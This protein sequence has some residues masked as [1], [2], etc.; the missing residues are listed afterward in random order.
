MS[1]IVVVGTQWG[2][3]GKGKI[4]DFLAQSADDVVRYQG[5]N[6]AGHSIVFNGNKYALHLIPSGIF[7]EKTKNIMANGMVINPKALHEEIE[8]LK[9]K[10]VNKFNLFISNRA[11]VIMPYHIALDG[12]IEELKADNNVGTT[13]KGIGPAYT[14]KAQRIGI[15]M[16]DFVNPELFHKRLEENLL[17][18]NKLLVALNKPTFDVEE[19]YNEYIKYSEEFKNYVCDTSI[20]LENEYNEQSKILF[21]GAQGVMLCIENGTY[22][23]VTSSS[24]TAASVPL[25]AGVSPKHIDEIIGVV[26]AYTT[27]VGSGVFPTEFEDD[28]AHYIRETAHEYGVTTG[29]PRRIGWIDTVILRHTKRVSGLTSLA[30]TLLDVLKNIKTLKICVAYKLDGEFI[31]Y[32]PSSYEDYER[33]EPVYI[34][35]DGFEEDITK[36]KDFNDL[37]KNA[38]NYLRKIE[39]LVGVE[40]GMFSVGPDRTQTIVMK[41]YF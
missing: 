23:F 34:E 20:I 33:C 7:N 8:T 26:K 19:I 16:G 38:K 6:N 12:A 30:I 10:N 9:A 25:Y 31:D 3:E 24:P 17:F 11:H 40:I 5:G 18:T 21:E 1:S 32:I 39:E 37:P 14:D 22:P 35:L 27:R 13:K 2:D 41:K 36:V 4:T 28:T 29:R 15:R